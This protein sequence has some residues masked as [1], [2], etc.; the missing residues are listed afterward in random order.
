MR[1]W[2]YEDGIGEA[3]AALIEDG[4]ILAA[5]IE[6]DDDGVR[7]GTIAEARLDRVVVPGR[8]AVVRLDSGEEA[9]IEPVPRSVSEGARLMVE[10]HR[11]ALPEPGRAKIALARVAPAGAASVLGPAL[12]DRIVAGGNSVRHLSAHEPDALEAAGWS[13]LLEEAAS[14]EAAFEGG[15]LRLSLTPAM[16]LIDVDGWLD[17]AALA[18]A[19]ADAA[20]RMIVRH[21]IAGSIGIDLPTPE[22]KAARLAAAEAV[23]AILPQPFERT[24]VNG[25]GFLQIVRRRARA[26]LPERMQGDPVAAAARALLRRAE[27]TPGAGLRTLS[28]APAV[29]ARIEA[30]PDWQTELA[31]RIGADIALRGDARLAISAG[32]VDAQRP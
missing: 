29:I 18:V 5:E 10:I 6:A 23:D 7:A 31:R 8:R 27:R 17:L 1:E 19:G 14:G 24:A 9:L 4:A 15:G 16:N 3:R 26:S 11:A 13:E 12:L 28:A 22:G 2:I 20:A 21:G 25:F 32:H 30:R